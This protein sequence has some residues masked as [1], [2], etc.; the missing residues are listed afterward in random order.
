MKKTKTRHQK[1][2]FYY[3]NFAGIYFLRIA[4]ITTFCVYLFLYNFLRILRIY[5]KFAKFA[6]NYTNK[7]LL[8]TNNDDNKFRIVINFWVIPYWYKFLRVQIFAN[9]VLIA[10]CGGYLFLRIP[11]FQ[12]KCVHLIDDN[13]F[14]LPKKIKQKEWKRTRKR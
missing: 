5:A 13:F 6:K 9:G 11:Y 8:Q 7:V 10:F 12:R 3:K 2:A 1:F 4:R 14:Y